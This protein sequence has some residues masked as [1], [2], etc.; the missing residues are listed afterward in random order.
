MDCRCLV[1]F[2]LTSQ[3]STSHLVDD[4]IRILRPFV[5]WMSTSFPQ[6]LYKPLFGLSA[7]TSTASLTPHLNAVLLQTK[8]LGPELWT[9]ADPQMVVI[10]LMGGMIP[11]ASK[12][13][14]KEGE[15][16]LVNVRMGRWAV[17]VELLVVLKDLDTAETSAAKLSERN[18]GKTRSRGTKGQTE[19]KTRL[20]AFI[21]A[22]EARLGSMLE[23]EVSFVWELD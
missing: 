20:R 17:L 9:N 11:K 23:T 16:G 19:K 4:D 6:Q 5:T 3:R 21:E 15:R 12:G 1:R 14:T 8:I 22:V 13:K 7:S 18:T 2:K 10:V